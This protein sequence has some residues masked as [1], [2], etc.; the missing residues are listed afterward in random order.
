MKDYEEVIG[1]IVPPFGFTLLALVIMRNYLQWRLNEFK[2][3][4]IPMIGIHHNTK[5][6]V[7]MAIDSRSFA[8]DFGYGH[9]HFDRN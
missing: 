4:Q 2:V 9:V 7:D 8:P 3:Q 5:A 1:L 6:L